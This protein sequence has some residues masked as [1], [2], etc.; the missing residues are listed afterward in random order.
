VGI[1]GFIKIEC[2][3]RSPHLIAENCAR[4]PLEESKRYHSEESVR[5]TGGDRLVQ[6]E[7]AHLN[8]DRVVSKALNERAAP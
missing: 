2:G 6:A 5:A 7:S 8:D 1:D 4:I 3:N